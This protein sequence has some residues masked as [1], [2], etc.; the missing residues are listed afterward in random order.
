MILHWCRKCIFRDNVQ[1][2]VRLVFDPVLERI[3]FNIFLKKG[4]GNFIQTVGGW[5]KFFFLPF[6]HLA[7]LPPFHPSFP[8][9]FLPFYLTSI[10]FLLYLSFFPTSQ[11]PS[12]L[13]FFHLTP[14]PSFLFSFLHLSPIFL[15]SLSFFPS[16]ISLVSLLPF[17][18][19]SF[20]SVPS[21]S[22]HFPPF[23][24]FPLLFFS[25]VVVQA[26]KTASAV[27]GNISREAGLRLSTLHY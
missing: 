12:F 24:S 15:P 11:S 6:L 20:I 14:S 25:I 22:F 3:I 5:Y 26:P 17:F 16:S 8:F 18:F 4:P 1:E 21:S 19:P 9:F 7:C 13:P 27:P 23:F 10:S 2:F